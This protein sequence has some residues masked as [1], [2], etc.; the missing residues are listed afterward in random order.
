MLMILSSSPSLKVLINLYLYRFTD[1]LSSF[2]SMIE[3][4]SILFRNHT[5][6][7]HTVGTQLIFVE[8]VECNDQFIGGDG[9]SKAKTIT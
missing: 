6:A 7:W 3:T 5:G 1:S 8:R 2:N 4:V 9:V